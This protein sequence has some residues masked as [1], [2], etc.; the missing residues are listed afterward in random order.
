MGCFTIAILFAI[1]THQRILQKHNFMKSKKQ[2]IKFVFERGILQKDFYIRNTHSSIR[3]LNKLFSV[4]PPF[5]EVYVFRNRLSFLKAIHKKLAPDWLVAY[6]PPKNTSSI[7]VFSNKEKLIAK[8]AGSYRQILL[9]EITHLYTNIL[10]PNLPD[11]LK[12]GISVYIAAQ[13]FKPSIVIVDWKKIAQKDIPF[14]RV[15]W[16]FAAEHNGYSIAGLLVMFSVRRYGWEK[17]IT[18]IRSSRSTR[19]SIKSIPL[20]FGEKFE[21]FIAEFKKQFIN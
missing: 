3:K 8:Q 20:Y 4:S 7:Y 12:E 9:H 5:I 19:F 16:K 17:F 14:K 21:P 13:I 2:R 1:F 6:V 18:A 10:N 15:S 11:W